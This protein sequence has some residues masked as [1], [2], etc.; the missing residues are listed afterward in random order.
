[1]AAGRRMREGFFKC[2]SIVSHIIIYVFLFFYTIR[3]SLYF[4]IYEVVVEST[5]L[6]LRNPDARGFRDTWGY[7]CNSG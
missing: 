7:L 1:V 4:G 2:F 6:S 5:I 3:L